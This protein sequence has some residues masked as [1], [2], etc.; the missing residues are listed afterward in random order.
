MAN[1]FPPVRTES[2]IPNKTLVELYSLE[3]AAYE[4]TSTIN[5]SLH[6]ARVLTKAPWAPNQDVS[7]RSVPG[8][9]CSRAHIVYC[10]PLPD[11]S[12]FIGLELHQPT[13]DWPAFTETPPPPRLH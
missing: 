4:I 3:N 12:F 13:G 6:G 2:R 5:V 10:K 1:I 8:N 9:F 7:V 11:N